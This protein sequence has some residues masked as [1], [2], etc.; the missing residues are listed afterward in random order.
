MTIT[1]SK[2]REPFIRVESMK[3]S[4]NREP[5]IRVE[6]VTKSYRLYNRQRDRLWESLGLDFRKNY[7]EKH[8]LN[9]VSFE[10]ARGETVG[11]IGT[12]GSGKSTP[13]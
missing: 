12:N 2:N 9:G 3:E 7:K 13:D 8:A 1:E 11:I 6:N 10:V 4:K 5:V